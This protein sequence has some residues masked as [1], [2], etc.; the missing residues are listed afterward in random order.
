M[1]RTAW[2]LS[3]FLQWAVVS[4]LW[5]QVPAARG[6]AFANSIVAPDLAEDERDNALQPRPEIFIQSR[7]SQWLGP[8]TTEAEAHL[9]FRLSRIETRWS[10]RLSDHFGTGLELQFHPLLDGHPEEIVNDAFLEWYATDTLTV[11]AG[12]FIKPFGFDIQQSSFDREYPERGNWAGYFFPGQRDRGLMA[13]WRPSA[14]TGPLAHAEVYAALLNGNRFFN[15]N[16]GKLDAVVRVRRVVPSQHA[17]IGAS[18]QIGSQI[19]PDQYAGETAVRLYGLDAQWAPSRLGL[20][21]EWVHGTRPSTLLSLDP[22]YTTAF[23][24]GT[25]TDGLTAAALVQVRAHDQV[26]ARFDRLTGDPM[27]A[28]TIRVTDIGYRRVFDDRTRLSI[29]YQWKNA[30][31]E[32]DDAVNTRLQISLSVEF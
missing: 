32:N 19:V 13:N 1:R 10:G 28:R 7:F 24:P 30:P 18:V 4:P 12:Q 22:E 25:V 27:T 23:A 6:S 9:N 16:D 17:A 15:D 29:A 20:R 14:K 3:L 11:R 5:A 2:V 8:E 26:F 21:A 31:T